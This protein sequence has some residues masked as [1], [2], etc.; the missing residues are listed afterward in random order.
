MIYNTNDKE[1]WWDTPI[2]TATKLKHNKPDLVIWNKTEKICI[3]IEFSC[4]ADINISKKIA[5]NTDT[6]GLL[7]WNLQVMY[8]QYRFMFIPIIVG[9]F[10]CVPKSLKNEQQCLRINDIDNF[11]RKIFSVSRTVK[12]FLTFLKFTWNNLNIMGVSF[13]VGVVSA[14]VSEVYLSFYQV[15]LYVLPDLVLSLATHSCPFVTDLTY[16]L[17]LL[18]LWISYIINSS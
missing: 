1:Y 17:H 16:L 4:P 11:T 12:I 9:A 15:S 13:C 6:Y 14:G 5:K 2:T 3:I 10:G 18:H 7:I 8:P